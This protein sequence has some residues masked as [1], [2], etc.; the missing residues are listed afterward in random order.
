MVKRKFRCI[1]THSSIPIEVLL[2]NKMYFAYAKF[3][4]QEVSSGLVNGEG[5]ALFDE[6][7]ADDEGDEGDG[8][9]VIQSGENIA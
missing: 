1:R 4:G 2:D 5:V 9:G 7:G 3:I 6:D 8:D